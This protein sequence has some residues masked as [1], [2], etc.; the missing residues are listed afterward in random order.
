MVAGVTRGYGK[1]AATTPSAVGRTIG[2][3]RFPQD[4]ALKTIL[5]LASTIVLLSAC[6][7]TAQ[8]SPASSG[9]AADKPATPA[10]PATAKVAEPTPAPEERAEPEVKL[11]S[12]PLT[13]SLLMR[14]LGAEIASQRGDWQTAYKAILAAAE[15]TRDPR[16][17]S[18]AVE[19]SLA[20]KKPEL[21]RVA[22]QLW[23]DLAPESEEAAQYYLSFAILT[24]D[25]ENARPVLAE[26]LQASPQASR[27][28]MIQ[29]T[30]R[31]LS[32]AT[33]KAAAFALLESV[34][35]PYASAPET[36]IALA[37]AAFANGDTARAQTEARRA[38]EQQPD[39]A[40][41]A[42]TLVQV[43]PDKKEA[44]RGLETFLAAHP[45]ARQ[46]RVT[47]ARLLTENR[48]YDKARA[49]FQ[50]MLKDDPKDLT[51][52]FALGIIDAQ[53][54]DT[55]SAERYLT[56]Y[57][58]TLSA[59]PEKD[60]DPTQALLLLAQLAEERKDLAAATA[61]LDRIEPGEA[62]I[63]AQ[64]KRAELIAKSGDV[65]GA[66]ASLSRI[67]ATG[68]QD[69]TQIAMAEAR[70]L[71]DAGQTQ[72]A[73]D[74]L[75]AA[76]ERFPD[77]NDIRYEY[78]LVA[79]KLRKFDTMETALR[80]IIKT[81]PNNQHAYNA[82]GYSFAER[83]IR[84]QE[85]LELIT[86]AL[87]LAPE[88]PFIMDSMGWVHFRLGNLQ[89]AEEYLRRA[90]AIRPDA[91]IGVHLGEVLWMKGEKEMA[92]QFWRDAKAKDPGNDTLK[93][94]LTRLHVSL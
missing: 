85:A 94:T 22:V 80:K 56:S 26:R 29:Q 23:R 45:K 5:A 72:D 19:I 92:Q 14:I 57:I 13:G 79:E 28:A 86:R 59:R 37:Q 18:R 52:L 90:Y 32:R 78:A 12:V 36:P 77:D 61:W 91:E 65:S 62:Y 40:Q 64:I 39:S 66:R 24:N 87:E 6:A 83:G 15:E 27:G 17:A 82:L 47:Y 9:A 68:Q 73:Y 63:G 41:A 88:D 4:L 43:T 16:L 30:Q 8:R 46:A 50:S 21:A 25:L 42:L 75:R 74:R 20:A 38:L 67:N 33:D 7:G 53:Q 71:R 58:D 49:E 51:S 44:I 31:L 10:A 93:T 34:L 2:I 69:Q 89:K 81:A 11:P 76:A 1:S 55:Q 54:G 70:I 60:R 84:L 35:A 48:E 3:H